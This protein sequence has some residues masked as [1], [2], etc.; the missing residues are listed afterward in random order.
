[1]RG[2]AGELDDASAEFQ[3]ED[4]TTFDMNDED[5]VPIT[6][7]TDG[8]VASATMVTVPAFQEEFVALGSWDDAAQADLLLADANCLPC[9]A[10]E[11][12]ALLEDWETFAIS[13]AAWDGAAS[14]FT[15]E[16]WFRST[17]LHRSTDKT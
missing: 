13:D 15:P 12:D 5:N 7:V 11:M 4:G 1:L 10:R 2:R 16:Q 6:V 14:R 3:Y 9:A 17:I 8:R